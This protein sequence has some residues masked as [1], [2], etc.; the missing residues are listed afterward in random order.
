MP[1]AQATPHIIQLFATLQAASPVDFAKRKTPAATHR[2]A[3]IDFTCG[4]NCHFEPLATAAARLVAANIP[5]FS[6][7]V[8]AHLQDYVTRAIMPEALSSHE[9]NGTLMDFAKQLYAQQRFAD[10]MCA[11]HVCLMAPMQDHFRNGDASGV[12]S[13]LLRRVK[14]RG[15]GVTVCTRFCCK[16]A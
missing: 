10:A 5:R 1:P 7:H 3:Y 4:A 14:L 15:T 16:P 11:W 2:Q 12:Q 13:L 9:R 8:T 6:A